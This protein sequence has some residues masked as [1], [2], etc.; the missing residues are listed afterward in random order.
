[1]GYIKV[2]IVVDAV[3]LGSIDTFLRMELLSWL[4]WHFSISF[5]TS[6]AERSLR[7]LLRSIYSIKITY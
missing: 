3:S 6:L 1:M 4:D 5:L 7:D 2:A